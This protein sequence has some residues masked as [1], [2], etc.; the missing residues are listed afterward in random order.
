MN[1]AVKVGQWELSWLYCKAASKLNRIQQMMWINTNNF[2]IRIIEQR[3]FF[4]PFFYLLLDQCLNPIY[5]RANRA[6]KGFGESIMTVGRLLY[7]I[8]I[9]LFAIRTGNNYFVLKWRKKGRFTP[10]L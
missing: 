7:S 4:P 2:L 10:F 1:P 8:S 6:C 9:S 3:Y 5:E